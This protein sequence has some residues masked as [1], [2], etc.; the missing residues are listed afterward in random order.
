MASATSRRRPRESSIVASAPLLDNATF[1]RL[2]VFESRSSFLRGSSRSFVSTTHRTTTS[3]TTVDASSILVE[4]HTIHVAHSCLL[5]PVAVAF[6]WYWTKRAARRV[7]RRIRR[8]IPDHA[9]DGGPTTTVD[10]GDDFANIGHCGSDDATFQSEYTARGMPFG[11]TPTDLFTTWEDVMKHETQDHS[12]RF[13][14]WIKGKNS[15]RKRRMQ[16]ASLQSLRRQQQT[17]LEQSNSEQTLAAAATPILSFGS[18]DDNESL[19]TMGSSPHTTTAW[20]CIHN[21]SVESCILQQQ[22]LHPH[23]TDDSEEKDSSFDTLSA[24]NRDVQ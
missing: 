20:Q 11:T 12:V 3:S 10:H 23:V 15:K 24:S 18:G 2:P 13:V 17:P 22:V 9:C 21:S 19:S 16:A 8:R 7:L 14:R 5:V 6:W 1:T 4:H